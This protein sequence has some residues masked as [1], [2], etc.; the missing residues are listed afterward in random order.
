MCSFA[1]T[2]LTAPTRTKQV[3]S[4]SP[5]PLASEIFNREKEDPENLS[6]EKYSKTQREL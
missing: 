4:K 6:D 5:G 3:A 1:P 2:T